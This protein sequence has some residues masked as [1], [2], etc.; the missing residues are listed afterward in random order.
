MLL[1]PTHRSPLWIFVSLLLAGLLVACGGGSDAPAASSPDPV[2]TVAPSVAVPSVPVPP[3]SN[4]TDELTRSGQLNFLV[5]RVNAGGNA[6]ESTTIPATVTNALSGGMGTLT[7]GLPL[8]ALVLDT[9]DG[10]VNIGWPGTHRGVLNL[11]G[12]AWLVCDAA[13]SAQTGQVGMSHNMQAVTSLD[14]LKGLNFAGYDCSTA[15]PVASSS[16]GFLADGSLNAD[17]DVV[18]E[19]EVA[20]LF[21]PDGLNIDNVNLKLR[22]YKIQQGGRTRYAATL[23]F[24]ETD[25]ST[26]VRSFRL[27]LLLS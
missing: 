22:A 27:E 13:S 1:S 21:S 17:G 6:I 7:L 19:A 14:E 25:T 9:A 5:Y 3:A 12:N 23:L 16:F 26:G 11:D 24:V 2:G 4:P 20:S 15:N 10:W 18:E 8:G